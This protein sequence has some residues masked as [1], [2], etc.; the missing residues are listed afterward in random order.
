MTL[1]S[2]EKIAGRRFRDDQQSLLTESITAEPPTYTPP[3][4]VGLFRHPCAKRGDRSTAMELK[5]I[6]TPSPAYY[7]ADGAAELGAEMDIK[8]EGVGSTVVEEGR[9]AFIYKSGKCAG[10]GQTA[11]SKAGRLVDAYDRPPVH[12]RVAR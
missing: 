8:G 10:C 9:F 5:E 11:R 7:V 1:T 4:F 12:G 2:E 6:Y 3:S